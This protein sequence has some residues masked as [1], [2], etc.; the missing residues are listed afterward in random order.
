[1]NI[2][3]VIL[4]NYLFLFVYLF[5]ILGYYVMRPGAVDARTVK[6]SQNSLGNISATFL[7][8]PTSG[9][10]SFNGKKR[11]KERERR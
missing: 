4:F 2:L 10:V 11:R 5:F 9:I 7:D 8:G 3:F 1:M 6:V